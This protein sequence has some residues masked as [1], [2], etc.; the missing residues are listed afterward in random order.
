VP[1]IE[2]QPENESTTVTKATTLI[3][4]MA[5]FLDTIGSKQQRVCRYIPFVNEKVL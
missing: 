5:T 1:V 4:F 3:M 2:A